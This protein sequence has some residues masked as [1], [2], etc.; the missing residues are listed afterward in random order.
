MVRIDTL[1]ELDRQ[2]L[3]A[4][5]ADARAPFRR[6]AEVLGTSD[7]TVARRFARLRGTGRVRVLG[8]TN[9][10]RLG[11]SVWLIRARSTP[12]AAVPI[13]EALARRPDTT[14]VFI[15]SGGTEI[16]CS[17]RAHD[18]QDSE[19][20]LLQK[21]P[22]TQR[23][24]DVSAQ[25]QLHV[26]YG[27]DAGPLLKSGALSESQISEL[28]S[29]LPVPSDGGDPVVLDEVDRQLLDLLAVDGRV[30]IDE[31]AERT[32]VPA[33]TVR[34]RLTA[35]R[36]SGVLY[37][38]VDFET[39]GSDAAACTHMW[40]TVSPRDLPSVGATLATHPEVAFAAATTGRTNI[41]C[42]LLAS[43]AA[44]L[45]RYLTGP[46]AALPGVR[47]VE[48]APVIRGFKGAGPVHHP[49]VVRAS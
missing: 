29:D 20:L 1:D 16:S 27:Y 10:E 15:T 38:D 25:Q 48:T 5:Q 41:Y 47:E 49:A 23:I 13:A 19:S 17:S 44:A 32:G 42:S 21:L 7:Q 35:L 31:L 40:L 30:P 22:R 39:R 43:D 4:L 34:R 36:A 3:A 45:Y 14:W 11:E 18:T 37:F 2:I 9:P 12:D 6:I 28:M 8:L 46:V 26:F 24:I 33:S